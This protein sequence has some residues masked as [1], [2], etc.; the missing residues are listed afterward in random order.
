MNHFDKL[1]LAP[2]NSIYEG[3][4]GSI[5]PCCQMPVS[6]ITDDYQ[7]AYWKWQHLRDQYDKQI[8]P[9]ECKKC[10]DSL[11][12]SFSLKQTNIKSYN[13]GYMDLLFSNKCNFACL[14]CKSSLSSTI[15]K[16]FRKPFSIA[17]EGEFDDSTDEWNTLN[18]KKIN[19]IVRNADKIKN[20]HLNG[21]E[22][23]LQE[24]IY[25]LLHYLIEKKLNKKIHVWTHTNGSVEKFKGMDMI[26]DYLVHFDNASVVMS[27]DNFE[28]RGEYVR[29]GLKQKKWLK[30]YD[31]VKRSKL[32]LNVHSCYNVFNCLILDKFA[33][34]FLDNDI[35]N[36]DLK[37]WQ[38]P[39]C[40][41]VDIIKSDSDLLN[42]SFNQIQNIPKYFDK[43]WDKNIFLNL[44]NKKIDYSR[45]IKL[46]KIFYESIT[47]F[48]MKRNTDFLH[49]FPE[50]K[51]IYSR[52]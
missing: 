19:F 34:W 44:L 28:K 6:Y 3:S 35:K 8:V 21:G 11:R 5:S 47:L 43:S 31:K 18:K 14:G 33:E 26:N 48:D 27:L 10:P 45:I 46:R 17:N 20:I 50:L 7:D 22:P 12:E 42:D 13:I 24:G 52:I 49:T 51:K 37:F 2:W 9:V 25:E 40:Y 41:S 36:V 16:R 23:F 29:W 32:F 1:C 38:H 4:R 15:A 30:I 39:Q